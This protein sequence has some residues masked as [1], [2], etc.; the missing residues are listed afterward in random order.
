[1][2]PSKRRKTSDVSGNVSA[3]VQTRRSASARGDPP[4]APDADLDAEPEVLMC[5]ITRTVFR[6]PVVVVD[7][8]HTY[9]RSAILS[10]F[11]R[12]GAKDPLTR[13]ALSSTKVMTLWSMR[14]VVQAWLDKHPGVTPDGW[15][16]RE[17]LEPSKDDGT[18]DDEGDVG[19]LRT[20][21]AM[22]PELQYMWPED[23]Q[24]EDWKGVTIENG[25]VVKLKLENFGLTGAVPADIGQLTSLTKL[26][27][28]RNQLTSLPAELGQLTSLTRLDLFGN[29]LTSVPAEIGQLTS[30]EG[31]DLRYNQLTSVP[32]EIGQLASLRKLSLGGN[33]LTSVPAEIGQLTS[34]KCL[35]LHENQLTSVPAEI[36]QLTS[37][38]L[39]FLFGNQLTSVPAEIGQ[40]TSLKE[41]SLYNN[42]LTSVPAEIGQLMSLV[43]LS[44]SGNQLTSLPAEI[45]QLTSLTWLYLDGNQLTSVP[46]EIGQLTS[47]RELFLGGNQLTSLPAVRKLRAA[48][49]GVHL[50]DGVT[51]DE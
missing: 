23:E 16:S 26:N 44:L 21:R 51:V 48:G 43:E 24:P 3:G 46:V 36:G 13:R 22:C 32:A 12:N 1:M 2:A 25:R 19:V 17:L 47:M 34:L 14:N 31:L 11:E 18:F 27:L 6:D 40:L 7:S 45:G 49:C 4:N 37:L 39:L 50:D 29:Q 28:N 5:P 42:Q 15:D 35:D 38:K 41:L 8:G 33:Q 9:E 30:L 10:H 20:W